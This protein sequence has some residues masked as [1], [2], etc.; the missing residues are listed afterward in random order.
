VKFA[1]KLKA[2]GV[3]PEQAEAKAAA[4]SEVLEVNLKEL[5]TKDES[6]FRIHIVESAR[7]VKI[8][9]FCF[10]PACDDGPERRGFRTG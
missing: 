5:A 2:A 7:P 8:R 6:F 1:N 3:P 10:T 4:L 9:E